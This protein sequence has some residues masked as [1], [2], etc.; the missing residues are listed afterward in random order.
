MKK[1]TK[2][3]VAIGISLSFFFVEL[4]IGIRQGSLAL[5]A[6]AFHIASGQCAL[7]LA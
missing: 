4:V 6:D 5:V 1:A 2:L 3:S 7:L